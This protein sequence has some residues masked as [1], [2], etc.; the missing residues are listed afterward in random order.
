MTKGNANIDI[1]DALSDPA[2]SFD[3]PMDVVTDPR[4]SRA[5]KLKLLTQW[6]RDAQLLAVAENEGM[7][8]GEESE[9]ARPRAAGTVPAW[10]GRQVEI[11]NQEP[12]IES[13]SI[14]SA[15]ASVGAAAT[16]PTSGTAF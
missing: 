5:A 3:Q 7:D 14:T 2:L 1:E 6:E 15:Q 8:G 10:P 9:H 13:G 16:S 12:E 4:L 11:V